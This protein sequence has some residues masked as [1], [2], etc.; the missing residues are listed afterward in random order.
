MWAGVGPVLVYA[1]EW[2]WLVM[3]GKLLV[4]EG[5]KAGRLS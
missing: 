3:K 5:I 4:G 1:E 2:R